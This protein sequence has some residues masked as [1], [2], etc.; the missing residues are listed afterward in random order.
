MCYNIF[1]MKNVNM[2]SNVIFG[3]RLNYGVANLS[4]G[5][6]R[7]ETG[8]WEFLSYFLVKLKFFPFLNPKN[9]PKKTKKSMGT[10][11]SENLG[12]M[13]KIGGFLAQKW[14]IFWLQSRSFSLGL[15]GKTNTATPINGK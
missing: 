10:K 13:R 9:G 11:N 8:F 2:V 6:P 7:T 5:R 3:P 1:S 4:P 12:K 15:S 14:H